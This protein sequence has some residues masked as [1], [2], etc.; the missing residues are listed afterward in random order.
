MEN[1]SIEEKFL[2]E[3]ST[4]KSI[5]KYKKATAGYGISYLLEHAYGEIYLKAIKEVPGPLGPRSDLRLLEFG[6]GAGM[7]LIHLVSLLKRNGFGIEAAWGS[8]FSPGLIQEAKNEAIQYLSAEDRNK[9]VFCVSRNEF[10]IDDLCRSKHCSKSALEN[11]F[12]F[13]VG[14]N[15]FRYCHRLQKAN[16]CAR[17]IY[18]LLKPGGICVVIDMNQ[19]YPL[20]RSALRDRL[21]KCSE[22]YY[23]PSLE[24]YAKPFSANGFQILQKENFCWIPHSAGPTMCALMSLVTPLLNGVARRW[25]MRSLVIARKP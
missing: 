2:R 3:Y 24:E 14:I 16:E 19:K 21:R 4:V 8:D 12:H 25:A 9:V 10:L 1:S 17:D 6:C 20:F 15:T 11:S 7:N 23:L 18:K 5:K 22:E 13:I